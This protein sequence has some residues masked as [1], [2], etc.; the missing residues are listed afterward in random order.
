M[1]VAQFEFYHKQHTLQVEPVQYVVFN[2]VFTLQLRY[3]MRFIS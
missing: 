3:T 1:P 2:E